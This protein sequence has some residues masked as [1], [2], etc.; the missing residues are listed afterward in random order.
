MTRPS[1][2]A[3]APLARQKSDFTAEGAPP[4][5]KVATPEPDCVELAKPARPTSH[6]DPATT[7]A[8]KG[9]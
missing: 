9:D 2:P 1:T 3:P 6:D 7:P 5:G 8:A 4:P